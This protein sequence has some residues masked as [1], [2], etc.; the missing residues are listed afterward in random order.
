[1][2]AL[3]PLREMGRSQLESDLISCSAATSVCEKS[4][5]GELALLLHQQKRRHYVELGVFICNAIISAREKCPQMLWALLSLEEQRRYDLLCCHQ[6]M[7]DGGHMHP[8]DAVENFY[9]KSLISVVKRAGSKSWHDISSW[10]E[11]P[12]CSSGRPHAFVLLS[13]RARRTRRWT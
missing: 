4:H 3:G 13:A 7:L 2:L 1:M 9:F 11:M 10:N 6:R 5:C 8:G 12:L